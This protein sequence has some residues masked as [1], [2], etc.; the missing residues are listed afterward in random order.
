MTKIVT[1]TTNLKSNI[2]MDYEELYVYDQ[3]TKFQF[4]PTVN[5]MRIS[6]FF[7]DNS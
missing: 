6:F 2:T 4:D 3:L 7:Q 1:L 5:E